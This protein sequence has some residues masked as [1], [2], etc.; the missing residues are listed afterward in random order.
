MHKCIYTN[1][2]TGVSPDRRPSSALLRPLKT[3]AARN[4]PTGK[5]FFRDRSSSFSKPISKD[6]FPGLT[7]KFLHSPSLL[8]IVAPAKTYSS[9]L[10]STDIH[11]T[12]SRLRHGSMYD[13]RRF[14]TFIFEPVF[15]ARNNTRRPCTTELLA[16][17]SRPLYQIVTVLC[18][19]SALQLVV[20]ASWSERSGRQYSRPRSAAL[21]SHTRTYTKDS[22]L[23]IDHTFPSR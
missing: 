10:C 19:L 3:S 11:T 22:C 5:M 6:C 12:S 1:K 23:I 13:S 21:S 2:L 7:A 18:R 4:F 14:T 20:A 17:A 15:S 9:I 8:F 16:F